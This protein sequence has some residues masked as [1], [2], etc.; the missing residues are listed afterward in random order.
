MAALMSL[1]EH[2]L[3]SLCRLSLLSVTPWMRN[4]YHPFL[5][6]RH[7]HPFHLVHPCPN[8]HTNVQYFIRKFFFSCQYAEHVYKLLQYSFWMN[9][10]LWSIL[11]NNSFWPNVLTG[12]AGGPAGPLS[13]DDKFILSED[14]ITSLFTLESPVSE[15]WGDVRSCR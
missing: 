9:S 8:S 13:N 11:C 7:N 4:L 14:D 5:V 6:S 2:Y 1:D 15:V 10:Q 3:S 12:A